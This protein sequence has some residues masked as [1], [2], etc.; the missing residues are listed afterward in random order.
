MGKHSNANKSSKR[1]FALITAFVLAVTGQTLVSLTA[2][3]AEADSANS[4]VDYAGVFDGTTTTTVS[5]AADTVIP[6]TTAFT[7]EAWIYPTAAASET[8]K[9]RVILTQGTAA[10]GEFWIA[11]ENGV[12]KIYRGSIASPGTQLQCGPVPTNA[13]T[14]VAVT[15]D[16]T[17]LNCFLNS[18]IAFTKAQTFGVGLGSKFT[19]G[20]WSSNLTDSNTFWQGQI[21]QVKVWNTALTEAQLAQSMH[22]YSSTGVTG[23]PTLLAHYD[24]NEGSNTDAKVYNRAGA[25]FDLDAATLNYQDIKNVVSGANIDS[26]RTLVYRFPRTYLTAQ[27]GWT[28]SSN[29]NNV[30]ILTVGGGG[31]GG[32]NVGSGGSGGSSSFHSGLSLSA[33]AVLGVKV[34]AGGRP[35]VYVD[36]TM[37]G[38]AATTWQQNSAGT[39]NTTIV[40]TQRNGGDGQSTVLTV[41]GTTLTAPGGLGGRTYWDSN[42]CAGSNHTVANTAAAAAGTGGTS[43]AV[44]GIGGEGN[45]GGA[46]VT[47]GNAPTSYT[48]AGA[49]FRFGGGGAGADGRAAPA[50]VSGGSDGGGASASSANFLTNS[51]RGGDGAAGTGGGGSGGLTGCAPGGAGGSGVVYVRTTGPSINAINAGGGSTSTL[52]GK[53][54]GPESGTFSL[55]VSSA[56]G[57]FFIQTVP[58]A[59]SGATI[60]SGSTSA[61]GSSFVTYQGTIAQ[62]HAAL[63]ATRMVMQG[64]PTTGS[65]KLELNPVIANVTNIYFNEVNGHYYRVATATTTYASAKSDAEN[66]ANNLAGLNGYLSNVTSAAEKDFIY[67]NIATSTMWAGG[68]YNG[69]NWVWDSGPEAGTVYWSGIGTGSA[70]AGQYANWGTGEPNGTQNRLVVNWT[71][72]AGVWDNQDSATLNP[73]LVEYGGRSTDPG[74]VSANVTV[75]NMRV[76]VAFTELN[77][78]YTAGNYVNLKKLNVDGA[79]P[80]LAGNTISATDSTGKNVG[81]RVLFKNVTTRDGKVID[82]IVTTRRI[83]SA[84]VKNY[85]ASTGAGGANSN[86]QADVD[87]SAANGYAEF[88]FDFY[89]T[90]AS[91]VANCNAAIACTGSNKVIL[92]N[93]SISM[94][95]IDYY[96]WNEISGMDSYTVSNPTNIKECLSSSLTSSTTC[97]ARANITTFPAEIRFQGTSAIN[98]T[99]PQDMA[100]ANYSTIDSFKIKFGRDRSGT[101][102][103]YG[104]SFKALSWGTATPQTIGPPATLYNVVYDGNGSTGGTAPSAQTGPVGSNF[105]TTGN[106]G[107]LV[108]SGYTFGGWNTMADGTGTAYAVGSAIQMPN[109]GMTLYAQWVPSQVT[110]TYDANGGISAPASSLNNA[111]ATITLSAT[112]PTRSGFTFGGWNTASNGSGTNYSSSA[113]YVMPGTNTT[114]YAKWTAATASIA[115]NG[116]S[117]TGGTAPSTTTGTASSATTTSTNSGSLVRTGYTFAGWN[118]AANGTGTDYATGAAINYPASGTTTLYAKWTA[119]SY[120]VA[121]N[122]NGGSTA[123]ASSSQLYGTTVTVVAA[124]SNPTRAGYTFAGWNTA[125]N[126]SGTAQAAGSTFSMPA[127]NVTLYAQWTAVNYN[128]SYN[129]NASS[130]QSGSQTDATNYNLNSTV[131]VLNAGTMAVTN[132]RFAGWNTMADGSGTDYIAGSTFLMPAS[133]V[134]LYAKWVLSTVKLTYDANGGFGAPPADTHSAGTAINLSATVPTRPGY[135]FGGWNLA[136]NGSGTNYASNASYTVP[137]SDTVLYAKWTAVNYTL[138]Y[139][140][141]GG[142]NGPANLLNQIVNT[143]IT[144]SNTIPTWIGYTFLG[145]NTAANGSGTDYIPGGT[146]TMPSNDVTLYAKWQGN[147]FTLTYDGN[148]GGN[149]SPN[150][151]PRTAGTTANISASL[152]VRAGYTFTGWNTAANGSGTS[153]TANSA[154]TMPGANLT[155]YAQWTAVNSGVSYDPNGGTGAPTGTNATIGQTVTVSNGVPTRTGYTFTGWN[156][157]ANG[158]GTPYSAGNTFTMGAGSIVFY[159]QWTATAYTVDYDANGGSGAPGSAN[160]SYG[161]TATV[162]ATVPTQLGYDFLGWN[163]ALNGSGTSYAAAATFTMPANNVTLYAQ[164][165]LSTYTVYYNANGGSGTINPQSGRYNAS[166]TLTNSMP[167]RSGFTFSGWNTNADGS[168]TAYTSGGAFT[169]PGSNTILYAQWTAITYTLTYDGNSGTGAPAAVTGKISGEVVPLSAT[170]PTRTGYYFTGWN[171]ASNGSGSNFASSANF[172]MPAAN[173]TLFATWVLNTYNV[174]YNANGGSG[175]PTSQTTDGSGNVTTSNTTP[176]RP[177]YTFNGWNTAPAGGG[178]SRAPGST[179]APSG[180]MVLYAQWTPNTITIH[181]NI[182]TGTGSTPADTTGT[183]G[184]TVVLAGIGGFSKTNSVFVSWNTRADG[185]GI[186]YQNDEPNYQLPDSDITLYA[187]WA[188]NNFAIDYR[189]NGGNYTPPTQYAAA[190]NNVTL[191]PTEPARSGYDFNG[192]QEVSTGNV[193]SSNASL[194]MPTSNLIMVARWVVRPASVPNSTPTVTPTPTPTPTPA[195]PVVT[196]PKKLTFTVYFKGDRAELLPATKLTLQ[197]IAKQA[198]VYGKASA[199]TIIG[200]VKET[201]D[202]SYDMRLSKQRA[203]N[204]AAYLKKLGVTGTYSVIASGISPENKPISRRVDGSLVWK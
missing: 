184:N 91:L 201:P 36:D 196:T 8:G 110:L 71:A 29:L 67:N 60:K 39:S 195:T 20:S 49:G 176:T 33:G 68:V 156:T 12:I 9:T 203:V 44:G 59:A 73:S 123:P 94:I 180:N 78:D 28:V 3:A 153:Y 183:Y 81:D 143:I 102:N 107:T 86:F 22:T 126:G 162:S 155:L 197:K 121:Y 157:A 119:V 194:T 99:I 191:T 104:V 4:T 101:P 46:G 98:N 181:Y 117:S 21:D 118:T 92:E 112:Q 51:P 193:Y 82:A 115:Y 204:V 89:E 111:G 88:Q 137:A 84:T 43:G 187:I 202:K 1:F 146:L 168:G 19:V 72:A 11:R 174:S 85:E 186:S 66:T 41:G 106:T 179:W 132:Y 108:R 127:N 80:T 120:T 109:G 165:S 160:Y 75:T 48:T 27:G 100:I 178:T 26:Y 122:T 103:Y 144:L 96:Q 131:T 42:Q 199:I 185:T 113:S 93:L 152:P 25:N 47:G 62:L 5:A 40:S 114:L 171:T 15:M 159:A 150:S 177:G 63:N 79:D 34:G 76:N 169:I 124:G 138:F 151:E 130:G 56:V 87:I 198:N 90:G 61:P 166:I 74:V 140:T 148:N 70:V 45:T 97:T 38:T 175:A 83:V 2:H 134:T 170:Q 17:N 35:G 58:L 55:T 95:D 54:S 158:S 173:T 161:A 172:T 14:H 128:V 13:W 10:T 50:S 116:N 18:S 7:A 65:V 32:E 64:T 135:T 24:F 145:W 37:V 164:W 105:T 189:A 31:G 141:N 167:T 139:N 77:F 190:G 182:N 192:W 147:A 23:A 149:I 6:A 163:T 129:I 125:A 52:V 16:G 57:T 133:N 69:T 200:R 136:A 30:E 154:L 188:G 53:I 142:S